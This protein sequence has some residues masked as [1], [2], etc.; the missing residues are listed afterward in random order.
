VHESL[1]NAIRH[2]KREDGARR[3][4]L[5]LELDG[6]GLEVCVRDEGGG[7]DPIRLPD[8]LAIE[9]LCRSSGRGVLLMKA[10]MDAVTFRRLRGGGM[11]VTM[12]KSRPRAAES[13]GAS[14]PREAEDPQL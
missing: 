4:T 8:P 14:T 13:R 1:V 11:E 12:R 9:N 3:V 5:E 6:C 7:F 10:L 2:G